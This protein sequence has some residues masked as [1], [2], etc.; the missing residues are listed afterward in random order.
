MSLFVHI[1][2]MLC[3]HVDDAYH[4]TPRQWRCVN[5]NTW[6]I[7]KTLH[8][9]IRSNASNNSN[10]HNFYCYI[11][12]GCTNYK[13]SRSIYTNKFLQLLRGDTWIT[14]KQWSQLQIIASYIY[15]FTLHS[16]LEN[17]LLSRRG[18][19]YNEGVYKL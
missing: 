19:L 13:N 10:S 9:T 3:L 14:H 6:N 18:V 7:L 12:R 8:H 1:L 4:L 5:R 16:N 11:M 17:S 15:M 2:Y